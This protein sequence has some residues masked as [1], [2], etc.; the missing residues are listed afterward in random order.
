MV[1][2]PHTIEEGDEQRDNPRPE[3]TWEAIR[4]WFKGNWAQSLILV[5]VLLVYLLI[6]LVLW[7]F[8]D[9]YIN[10]QG[11]TAKKDLIQALGLIMAG[12][13]GAI[14]IYFTWRNLT[15]TQRNM[16]DTQGNT[17]EQLNT[18]QAQLRLAEEGQVTE[19]FTK[20]IDQLGEKM[21]KTS[22][23]LRFA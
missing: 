13:A 3:T 14:G 6:G 22:R 21:T 4:R 8:L 17:Q 5:G 1:A 9:R 11:S 23:A 20:V 18:A 19:R 2:D 12:L 15:M 16:E 7:W 10:P